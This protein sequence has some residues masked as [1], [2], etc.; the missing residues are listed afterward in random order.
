M[1]FGQSVNLTLQPPGIPAT[2]HYEKVAPC[3][4]Q[5]LRLALQSAGDQQRHMPTVTCRV[6]DRLR[7]RYLAMAHSGKYLG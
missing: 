3:P 2:C 5:P 4:V 7:L 1:A 6:F